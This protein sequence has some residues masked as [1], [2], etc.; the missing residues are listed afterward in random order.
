MTETRAERI[1]RERKELDLRPWEFAPSEVT[2]GPNPYA[3]DPNKAGFASW[4]K[5]Q[6]L[7][8]QIR[9]KCPHYFDQPR[10]AAR[11]SA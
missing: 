6:E 4:N 9:A 3:D 10:R 1:A 8:R 5:A 2:D 11:R 7:R